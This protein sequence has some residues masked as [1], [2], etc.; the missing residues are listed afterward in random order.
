MP[1]R[2]MCDDVM[3]FLEREIKKGNKYDAVIMDPPKFGRGPKGETWNIE[4]IYQNF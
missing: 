3:K 4:K 1:M 2:I